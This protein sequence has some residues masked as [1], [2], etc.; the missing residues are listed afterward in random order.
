[1]IIYTI[2]KAQ[3][4]QIPCFD[5]QD[6]AYNVSLLCPVPQMFL[7]WEG[8]KSASPCWIRFKKGEIDHYV[9]AFHLEVENGA[10]VVLV[11]LFENGA[12]LHTHCASLSQPEDGNYYALAQL[13][14]AECGPTC[15][16]PS[17]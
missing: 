9:A 5:T 7:A 8:I 13:V 6:E 16:G 10:Q 15:L 4:L 2:H 17:E 3:E 11:A 1:M 12:V 14:R